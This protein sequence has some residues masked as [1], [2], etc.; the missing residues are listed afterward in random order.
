MLSLILD[1]QRLGKNVVP[2]IE[3]F[4][5]FELLMR[6]APSCDSAAALRRAHT[7]RDLAAPGAGRNPAAITPSSAS[8]CR[9]W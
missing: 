9:S 1:A 8:R 3:K 6:S 2:I 4:S 5:E 7:P